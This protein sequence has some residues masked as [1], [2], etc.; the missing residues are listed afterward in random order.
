MCLFSILV[1]IWTVVPAQSQKLQ[2]DLDRQFAN[3]PHPLQVIGCNIV[4]NNAFAAAFSGGSQGILDRIRIYIDQLTK[5]GVVTNSVNYIEKILIDINPATMKWNLSKMNWSLDRRTLEISVT[6]DDG[7]VYP[8]YQC[9]L[10][11]RQ[12]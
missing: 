11:R 7:R 2:D 6:A 5:K 8:L 12:L 9:E 10:L 1:G 4:T 3:Y